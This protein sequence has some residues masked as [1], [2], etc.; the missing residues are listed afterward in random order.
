MLF[1]S[2]VMSQHVISF[3][4]NSLTLDLSR[5]AEMFLSL[6]PLKIKARRQARWNLKLITS[7]I[8]KLFLLSFNYNLKNLVKSKLIIKQL[9][10][11]F[12]D[13]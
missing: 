9:I 10:T 5:K 13:A 11:I 8:F 1:L 2:I 4:P 3:S 7:R 6:S 12:L